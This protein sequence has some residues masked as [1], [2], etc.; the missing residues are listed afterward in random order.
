[1]ADDIES[2]FN[3]SF[4][5][6]QVRGQRVE[7][8]VR[9]GAGGRNRCVAFAFSVARIIDEQKCAARLSTLSQQPHPIEC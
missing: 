2:R 5:P 7:H 8:I 4:V 6:A 1:M 3:F 9:S